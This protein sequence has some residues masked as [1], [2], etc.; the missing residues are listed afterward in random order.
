MNSYDTYL[1]K[2]SYVYIYISRIDMQDN[3]HF[4]M[5]MQTFKQLEEI[6]NILKLILCL[7]VKGTGNSQFYRCKI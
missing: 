7:I 3:K 6:C 1:Q 5:Y 4:M 2:N